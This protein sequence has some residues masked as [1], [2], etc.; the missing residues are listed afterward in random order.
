MA[1]S[2]PVLGSVLGSREY[3]GGTSPQID[4]KSSL[5]ARVPALSEV[6][7]CFNADELMEG[8]GGWVGIQ[9]LR[10]IHNQKKSPAPKR[11]ETLFSLVLNLNT[12][13]W[14]GIL[15]FSSATQPVRPNLFPTKGMSL[16]LEPRSQVGPESPRLRHSHCAG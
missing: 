11:C 10:S 15:L 6:F 3:R 8:T 12:F 13:I 5:P 1:K 2:K 4:A 9:S 14:S 16:V 7:K